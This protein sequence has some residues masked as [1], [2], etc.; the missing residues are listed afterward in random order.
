KTGRFRLTD[1][2]AIPLKPTDDVQIIPAMMGASTDDNANSLENP[3]PFSNFRSLVM[4]SCRVAVSDT[5]LKRSVLLV[6]EQI[7]LGSNDHT[8]ALNIWEMV[9]SGKFRKAWNLRH[10]SS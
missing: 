7:M 8:P 9:L 6:P 4:E 10:A 3:S 1:W 5:G 2:K